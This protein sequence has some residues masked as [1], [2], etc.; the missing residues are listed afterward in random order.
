M[1]KTLK[2]CPIHRHGANG[3]GC[4]CSDSDTVWIED[5]KIM[6]EKGK[7]YLTVKD[8]EKRFKAMRRVN[9]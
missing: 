8:V 6:I 5:H 1:K 4:Y 9:R 3:L 7:W 2:D